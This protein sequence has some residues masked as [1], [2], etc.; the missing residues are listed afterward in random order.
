MEN[1]EGMMRKI[2]GLLAT[3]ES[4]Q[5]DPATVE[6]AATYRAKAESLMREY[7]IAEE[8]LIREQVSSGAPIWRDIPTSD[9][10]NPWRELM[11]RIAGTILKHCGVEFTY[12]VRPGIGWVAEAVGY[13]MDLRLAEMIWTSTRLAFL[14]R[15]E[16]EY[17][18]S[19][20]AEENIYRLRGAGIDRQR[21]A[22]MVFGQE[23]HSEG[24]KVGKVYRTEC[25][26]RGE[27]DGVSG[28]GF[29][30]VAY[31]EAYADEFARTITMRLRMARDAADSVG[32]ALVLPERAERV[33][34]ALWAR[35]PYLRPETPEQRKEREARMAEREAAMTDAERAARTKREREIQ[36]RSRW[37]KADE[38]KYQRVH[39][40]AADRA[41][42]AGA[43][44][45]RSV[46]LTREAPKE[47]RTGAG[48]AGKELE[49]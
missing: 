38:A 40:P 5:S 23:G 39:G 43:A 2:A 12:E 32:G 15:M 48:A 46:D 24:I 29:N 16:P 19:L 20:S 10:S 31:R 3:A 37:T 17:D 27:V 13:D 33:R 1:I 42:A 45:A 41:R 49:D 28:R 6:A 34:E 9:H 8:Q 14:A 18:A 35:Y 36:R 26:R 21:V 4:F 44:A 7:R 47:K 22:K 11:M 30:P 25:E